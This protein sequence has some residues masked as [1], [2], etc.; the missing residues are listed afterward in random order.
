MP[1]E[2]DVGFIAASTPGPLDEALMGAACVEFVEGD[3]EVRVGWL[4]AGGDGLV[5][6]ARVDD[7]LVG[8]TR[9]WCDAQQWRDWLAPNLPVPSWDALPPS[10]RASAASL[11]LATGDV[12][13]DMSLDA[14]VSAADAA[15]DTS[16]WPRATDVAA[17]EVETAWRVGMV[18]Q[19]EGRRL[20]LMYLD[21]ATSWLC[22]RC[23]R[24]TPGDTALDPS[25]LPT[26]RCA[27]VAGWATLPSAQ[28]E[29]LQVGD[30][31]LL[32]VAAHIAGGE[33][34][35]V[36]GDRAM[37]MRD[38][39]PLD[40]RVLQ[41]DDTNASPPDDTLSTAAGAR[42]GAATVR[43]SA[44]VAERQFP[45]PFLTAWRSGNDAVSQSEAIACA[46]S[47]DRITLLRDDTPWA[48]GRLLRFDDGR[49]AVC[50]DSV[51]G[52]FAANASLEVALTEGDAPGER[53]SPRAIS[54]RDRMGVHP[55]TT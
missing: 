49:L 20:A 17:A 8:Q 2:P 50:I 31:V 43:L 27:L 28:C 4:R 11:T 54:G 12:S 35:L 33:Y 42:Q 3:T 39:R 36:D 47:A 24:A 6:T 30:A 21:G 45:I 16:S 52:A 48:V 40:R 18:L 51:I 7:G 32:D 55:E 53:D 22:E 34:W 23:R 19:R 14:A 29:H 26:R 1:L 25:G 37:A 44:L 5:V 13:A 46:L 9:F 38:G 10:W 15:R 41:L